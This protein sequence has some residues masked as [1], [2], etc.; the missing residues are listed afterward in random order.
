MCLSRI[1]DISCQPCTPNTYIANIENLVVYNQMS[2]T[3]HLTRMEDAKLTQILF[4]GEL[5]QG[6]RPAHVPKS[7]EL[8]S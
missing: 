8:C 3:G 4:Y 6:N 7:F 5:I 1:L 2:G